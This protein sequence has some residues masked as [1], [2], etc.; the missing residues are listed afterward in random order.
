AA[1]KAAERPLTDAGRV[2][3]RARVL[4]EPFA[5]LQD[6]MKQVLNGHGGLLFLDVRRRECGGAVANMRLNGPG[7]KRAERKK[8]HPARGRVCVGHVG[9]PCDRR[10]VR[11]YFAVGITNSAPLAMLSGQRC[12]MLFWRV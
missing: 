1:P 8:A 7:V 2:E 11:C 4:G 9:R 10:C 3:R 6:L 5:G 12:M